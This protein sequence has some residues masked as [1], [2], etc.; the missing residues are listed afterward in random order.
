MEMN[1]IPIIVVDCDHI[2][3]LLVFFQGNFE[4]AL[5]RCDVITSEHIVIST[6][7]CISRSNMGNEVRRNSIKSESMQ[8]LNFST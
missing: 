7:T 1:S 3:H 8:L 4:K 6:N 2:N 5:H